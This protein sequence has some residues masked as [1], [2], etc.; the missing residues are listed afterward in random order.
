MA[1]DVELHTELEQ[2]L[3]RFHAQEAPLPEYVTNLFDPTL[4]LYGFADKCVGRGI[5]VCRRQKECKCAKSCPCT[6]KQVCKCSA[7]KRLRCPCI[8]LEICQCPVNCVCD[9]DH[10]VEMQLTKAEVLSNCRFLMEFKAPEPLNMNKTKELLRAFF[11][12][13]D[14]MEE[15]IVFDLHHSKLILHCTDNILTFDLDD[16]FSFKFG[17]LSISF[18]YMRYQES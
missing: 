13:P 7:K 4:A 5:S 10:F 9:D 2:R 1:T 18:D 3:A 8:A 16:P 11:I 15:T 14:T 12:D 6:S 17:T